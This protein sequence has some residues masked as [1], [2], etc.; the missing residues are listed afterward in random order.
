[1]TPVLFILIVSSLLIILLYWVLSTIRETENIRTKIPRFN[2]ELAAELSSYGESELYLPQDSIKFIGH[3]N[4]TWFAYWNLSQEKLARTAQQ[5][6]TI[7][8][9]ERI[10]L[11][12]Y[13]ISEWQRYFDIEVKSISGRCRFELQAGVSYY[14]VLG[15]NVKKQFI[16][17]LTSQTIKKTTP[18]A[19]GNDEI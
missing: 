11:R 3:K 14:V 8:D 10:V 6:D 19:N 4:N 1:M 13:E 16:P 2:Y 9:P 18:T 15:M 12:L 5:H 17:M 7:P